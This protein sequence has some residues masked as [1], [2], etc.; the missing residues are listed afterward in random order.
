MSKILAVK[1]GGKKEGFWGTGKWKN[2]CGDVAVGKKEGLRGAGNGKGK[3]LGGEGRRAR[4]K[5]GFWHQKGEKI[6]LGAVR[7]GGA[8][9]G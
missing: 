8:E 4:K 7:G 6:W 2:L 3:N 5:E 1:K 9:P